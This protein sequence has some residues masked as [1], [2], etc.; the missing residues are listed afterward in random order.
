MDW[1]Y[2]SVNSVINTYMR[3]VEDGTYELLVLVRPQNSGYSL[4]LSNMIFLQQATSKCPPRVL[5]DKVDGVDAYAT[6]DLLERHPMRPGLWKIYGR[7]DDQIML[8]NGEK[9]G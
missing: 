8:S 1:E 2:F 5:N 6:N 3:P 7:V 4:H 9:V